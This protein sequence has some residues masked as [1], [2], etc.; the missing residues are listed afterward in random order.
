MVG[1]IEGTYRDGSGHVIS[2]GSITVYITGTSTVATTYSDIAC[3]IPYTN[4]VSAND[5][6]FIFYVND[7]GN[8]FYDLVLSA[9][10]YQAKTYSYIY[11][12]GRSKSS[13]HGANAATTDGG[14]IAHGLGFVPGFALLTGTVAQQIVT[15]TSLDA[16]NITVAIKTTA[17]ASGTSQ[18]VYWM[19]GI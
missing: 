15:V 9:V 7:N 5:G 4:I 16:T 17:G 1:Q 18:V 6:S 12:T 8:V 10:G 19:A 13:A 14:T 3:T 2:G 11:P